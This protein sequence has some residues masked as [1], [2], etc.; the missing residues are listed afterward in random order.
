VTF[1]N[2][3]ISMRVNGRTVQVPETAEPV[4]YEIT[5]RGRRTL[6]GTQRPTC[7]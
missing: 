1:G 3:Q 5:P 7:A 2:G 4:G 6:S